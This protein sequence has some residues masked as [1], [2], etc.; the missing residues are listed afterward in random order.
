MVPVRG[1]P[2]VATSMLPQVLAA[3]AR[4]EAQAVVCDGETLS[5]RDLDETSNR[6]A[7]GTDRR[8]SQGR[9]RLWPWLCRAPST[10]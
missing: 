6:W 4:S 10:L 7:P 9:N 2:S 3:A 5:Y 8:R 1:E